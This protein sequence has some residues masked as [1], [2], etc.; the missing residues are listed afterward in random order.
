MADESKFTEKGLKPKL[1]DIIRGQEIGKTPSHRHIW[2][3][4]EDCG[5]ERWVQLRRTYPCSL[6]CRSCDGKLKPH[7]FGNRA[8]NWKGGKT[9]RNGYIM[10]ML[11]PDDFFYS[12]T[13][14]RGYVLEHRLVVAKA[15]GRNLHS[16]EI[17]HHKGDKYP[18]NSNED[19]QDNR[20]PENLQL[21]T[22]DRH[23]QIT[24]LEKRI[25]RLEDK[26][27]EQGKLIKLLQWKL[28]QGVEEYA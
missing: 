24:I 16:W 21:V 17:V 11:Q 4:C 20:Y 3:A 8:C 25:Q 28:K 23:K 9:I 18:H 10:I 5:K 2:S 26:V 15:L 22:D 7:P 27:D 6:R 1:G 19:K 13:R 12:M 14:N